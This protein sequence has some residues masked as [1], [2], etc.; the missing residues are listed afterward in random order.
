M[1]SRL[2]S[3]ILIL[4]AGFM[5]VYPQE[6]IYS[7]MIED[8]S[9]LASGEIVRMA[10]MEEEKGDVGKALVLYMVVCD[11]DHSRMDDKE[12][13]ICSLAYFRAGYLN[14]ELGRY[15]KALEYYIDGLKICESTKEKKY[16]AKFYKDIGIIYSV[17]RDYEK[18]LQYYRHGEKLLREN[19]DDETEYKLQTN[20]FF[21][22]LSIDDRAGADSAYRRIRN[23]DYKPTDLSRFIDG[24]TS[25]LL[26][27]DDRD[28]SNAASEFRRLAAFARDNGIGPQYEGSAYEWLYKTYLAQERR[29]SAYKY[30]MIC[31]ELS[32]SCGQTHRFAGTLRDLAG[33]YE[34]EGDRKTADRY[35]AE[36]YRTMDSIFNVREFDVVKNGQSV[37]EMDKVGREIRDLTAKKENRET[38]L[39][40]LTGILAVLFSAGA[41]VTYLLMKVSRQKRSLDE[42]YRNLYTVNK[43]LEENHEAATSRYQESLVLIEQKDK[44]LSVLR[45][46]LRCLRSESSSCGDV[47]AEE[48]KYGGSSLSGEMKVELLG[49]IN[50]VMENG[51]EYCSEDFTLDRLAVMVDSNTRYVSQVINSTYGKNFN[52]FINEYR[53]RMACQRLADE[54]NYGRHTIGAIGQS[55]GFKSNTTFTAVFRRLTGMTPSVYQ[56][57]SREAAQEK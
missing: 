13:E 43:R 48:E 22:C 27:L 9:S 5:T 10:Q 52:N 47:R 45:E 1:T 34:Q 4:L 16:A 19:P 55:V 15:T 49:K 50:S 29:D 37:Y 25:A 30:M 56:R 57:M 2:I 8:V 23:L 39:R 28:Y 26:S 54:K 18:G 3:V 36:Y 35:R 53:I 7:G 40:Y 51:S 12:K 42:S 33:F 41:A 21:D 31:Q 24:Y 44:E 46:E 14:Y 6:R 38:A 20:I 32:D 11:R 17:F